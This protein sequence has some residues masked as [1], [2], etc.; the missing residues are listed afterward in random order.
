MLLLL[1]PSGGLCVSNVHMPTHMRRSL[2]QMFAYAR[3]HQSACLPHI[4][5]TADAT[6]DAVHRVPHSADTSTLR[7]HACDTV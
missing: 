5:A 7:G 6:P 2:L 1:L 3:T 4:E